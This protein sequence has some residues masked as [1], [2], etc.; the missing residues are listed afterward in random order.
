M[1][2]YNKTLDDLK[3]KLKKVLAEKDLAIYNQEYE[4]AAQLRDKQ[5]SL[6]EKIGLLEEQNTI[7]VLKKIENLVQRYE[8]TK[9]EYKKKGLRFDIEK[10][11]AVYALCLG[12]NERIRDYS[13]LDLID[14]EFKDEDESG[15]DIDAYSY[16]NDW[17]CNYSGVIDDNAVVITKRNE[18]LT[19]I[20]SK[21]I[22]ILFR[23]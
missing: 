19:K 3:A 7:S 15:R 21:Y 4:L 16:I 1:K 12:I 2:P 11:I 9:E 13:L 22:A 18:E 8:E 14:P 5:R 6:S 10:Q 23:Q 20:I 17:I